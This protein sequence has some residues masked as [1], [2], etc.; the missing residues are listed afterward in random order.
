MDGRLRNFADAGLVGW[1]CWLDPLHPI[2]E[3]LAG[4]VAAI[5]GMIGTVVRSECLCRVVQAAAFG[6]VALPM[7]RSVDSMN[8]PGDAGFFLDW[9]SDPSLPLRNLFAPVL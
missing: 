4:P 1:Q 8:R 7:D 3:V 9:K 6:I 2:P 5:A